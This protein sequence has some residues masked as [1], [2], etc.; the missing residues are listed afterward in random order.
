MRN[1][2]E[3][4]YKM[5]RGIALGKILRFEGR[6]FRSCGREFASGMSARFTLLSLVAANMSALS[7]ILRYSAGVLRNTC[8][9]VRHIC[10]NSGRDPLR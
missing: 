5:V 10:N 1:K 3:F 9:H 8:Q 7:D 4:E 2:F 6:L